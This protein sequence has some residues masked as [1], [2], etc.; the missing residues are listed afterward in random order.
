MVETVILVPGIGLSGIEFF[1]LARHL[2][3]HGYRVKIFWKNP[4]RQGLAA[5]AK[6]LNHMLAEQ[7]TKMHHLVAHSLGGLVALQMLHDYP[8]QQVGR[9]V[10]LG[11]PLLG[12]LAAR[13]VLRIPGGHWV[14]GETLASVCTK[15]DLPFPAAYGVGC[16]AGRLNFGL[17][18]ALCPHKPND[19]LVC[20]EETQHPHLSAHC[21]LFV[22]HTSMLFS[23]Q[24]SERVVTFL[25]SGVFSVAT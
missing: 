6:A 21:V 4:W 7:Q 5:N 23:K 8:Q 11:T 3:N 16:I 14:I 25:R 18:L 22:S 19:T 13:R 17:G 10:M 24:V 12:C 20:V 9:V 1:V 15:S 2:R